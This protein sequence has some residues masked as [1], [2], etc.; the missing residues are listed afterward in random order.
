MSPEEVTTRQRILKA[1]VQLLGRRGPEKLTTRQIAAEA[2]V[3]VAAI[4]YHFRSKEILV[5]EA[6]HA[7]SAKAFSLGMRVFSEPAIAP[8][9]RLIRFFQGYAHGLVEFR[10]ATRTA[11]LG[12]MTPSSV[13]GKYAGMTR[14]MFAAAR[15]CIREMTGIGEEAELGRRALLLFSGVV[16]P[17]LCLELFKETSGVDYESPAQRDR[18]IEMLVRMLKTKKE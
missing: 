14:E 11:F 7:F 4:N 13:D 9:E 2:G 5:D 6:I 3:N 17:F 12:L 1:T 8:E 16:F 15:G 10:G 18:F